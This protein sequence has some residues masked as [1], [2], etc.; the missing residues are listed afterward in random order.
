MS[1]MTKLCAAEVAEQIHNGSVIAF[2]GFTA[3]GTAKAVARELSQ[4]AL[5]LHEKGIPFTVGIISGA[6]SGQSVEGDLARANALKFRAPFSANRDFRSHTNFGQID[7]EDTHVGHMAE[8]LR[9]GYY[10]KIDWAIIEVSSVEIVGDK[11][12]A[13]LTSAVG[14]VPTVVRLAEKVVLELNSFH[15][16]DSGLLH[17]IY[18]CKEWP[19]REPIPMRRINA[20][21]GTQYIEVDASKVI[22]IVE[23]H[24]EEESSDF[25]TVNDVTRAIGQ[26][27][28]DF[29]LNEQKQG[30]IPREFFPIQSGVGKTGNSV[31][32]AI[33]ECSGLPV[34]NIYSEVAQDAVV[35]MI[36]KGCVDQVSCTSLSVTNECLKHVYDDIDF[37]SRHIVLRPSELS[38]SPEL[39]RRF[40]VIAMNT[41]IE[42]D[43]YGDINSSHICGSNL[44]NG[45]GGSAD[46]ARN[47]SITIFYTPSV[48]KSG[49]VSA[50]VPFC[51]HIDSSEH[52]VDVI[53]TE[54]GIADL[55]GKGPLKRARE[56]IENCAHPDYKN[57]LRE[58]LKIAEQGHE[59]QSMRAAFAFHDTYLRK[60]SMRL[61]EFD[62]YLK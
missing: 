27:V 49:K 24:I 50:I 57:L 18:E 42:C 58:Y 23:S 14:C 55:R 38:N 2:S 32:A 34:M 7:F 41:A 20:R 43:L 28:V 39:I 46:Y 6:N 12:R 8:R 1:T 30:R 40:G 59:P 22:G 36:E 56:I 51:S 31:M 33:A 53:I 10:G 3:N 61:T 11:Y 16:P 54:R 5:K 25:G 45:I 35:E 62:R 47:G 4:R 60:G 13:T 37:F 26:N 9:R 21:I 19:D 48:T 15:S 52:D 29:L 44:M 17:D